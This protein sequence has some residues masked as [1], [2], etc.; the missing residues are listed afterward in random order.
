MKVGLYGGMV[1]N[2]YTVAKVMRRNGWHV[3]Y[4]IEYVADEVSHQPFWLD[5]YWQMTTQD[6]AEL[7]QS[8]ELFCKKIGWTQPEWVKTVGAA[9]P[10]SFSE[11]RHIN[12]FWRRLLFMFHQWRR[13]HKHL[14][15]TVRALQDYDCIIACGTQ[16]LIA[17]RMSG[18]PYIALIHGADLRAYQNA[19]PKS[20]RYRR[21][22][23]QNISRTVVRDA[24]D[25]ASAIICNPPFTLYSEGSSNVTGV[26]KSF[27]HGNVHEIV[28]PTLPADGSTSDIQLHKDTINILIPSRVD[29]TWKG[30]DIFFQALKASKYL[31]KFHAY[32]VAWGN[33][34]AEAVALCQQLALNDHVTFLP[35]LATRPALLAL[36]KQFDLVVD[37]FRFGSYG[38]AVLEALSCEKPVLAYVDERPFS[39]PQHIP[40]I[41]RAHNESDICQVLEDIAEG[42]ID[43]KEIGRQSAIWQQNAAGDA[44]FMNNMRCVF[45]SIGL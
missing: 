42:R 5:V 31:D 30:Q 4:L 43:L 36:Y 29:F 10:L 38:T 7:Q 16:P 21:R 8:P 25:N 28:Y 12:G 44:A 26:R 18:K 2:A 3:D 45:K 32:L 13:R 1:N 15:Q 27:F 35:F 33:N 6:I 41:I 40:P 19:V 34:Q 22:M 23:Y 24:I 37:D 14:R 17:A 11:L 39:S 9:S 20:K